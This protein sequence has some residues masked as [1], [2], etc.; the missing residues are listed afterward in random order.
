MPKPAQAKARA[1]ARQA[2]NDV[3]RQHILEAAEKVFAD[4]GFEVAKVQEISSMAGLS[5]GTIYAI[6]PSKADLFRA[7][8]EERGQELAGLVREATARDAAPTD[9]LS[10]LIAL[11]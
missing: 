5:M 8:A 10:A 7:I 11:Y 3:Y 6:F 9:A 1:A 4:R 2:R